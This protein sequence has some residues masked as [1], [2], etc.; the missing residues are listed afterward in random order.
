MEELRANLHMIDQERHHQQYDD[1]LQQGRMLP[2]L[3]YISQERFS[4]T[5]SPP[6]RLG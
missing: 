1:E 2:D 6:L 5:V 3:L 4:K